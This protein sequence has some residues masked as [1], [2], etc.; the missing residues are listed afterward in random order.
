MLFMI[1]SDL[2]YGKYESSKRHHE[3]V[4]PQAQRLDSAPLTVARKQAIH[5]LR[6]LFQAISSAYVPSDE[7]RVAYLGI[8][9][10]SSLTKGKI[11][12]FDAPEKHFA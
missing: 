5:R 1:V 12:R 8:S 7:A 4:R 2:C 6:S 11:G 10:Y 3:V 9:D